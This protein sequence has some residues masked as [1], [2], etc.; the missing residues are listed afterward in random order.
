MSDAVWYYA[1]GDE[2]HGP[3]TAVQL[4]AL[5]E[6]GKLRPSDL[7]WKEGMEDWKPANE[8]RGLFSQDAVEKASAAGDAP[9]EPAAAPPT[10]SVA[11]PTPSVAPAGASSAGFESTP[12]FQT[13]PRTPRKGG[14]ASA[15]SFEPLKYGR[16]F[17]QPML[18]LGLFLV[19]TARG[20]DAVG[21]RGVVGTQAK[22]ERARELSADE[23]KGESDREEYAKD[24]EDY[25]KSAKY[26][27]YRNQIMGY[28]RELLF[29]F[30][31]IVLAIG[32]LATG[33]TS[34]GA[35]RWICLI[36]LSILMFAYYI[37]G[38]ASIHSLP[39]PFLG[40]R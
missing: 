31:T 35:G 4:K 29:S 2:E 17:G 33:F 9:A 3:V 30:G 20:C 23:D 34:E 8:V 13:S 40:G 36:M 25:A 18:L 16:Y 21:N 1:Q 37:G 11:P 12:S 6:Q 38:V 32:L 27:R 26:A 39:I 19:L 24:A 15:M 10:S 28:W 7:V 14:G 5:A 22:A